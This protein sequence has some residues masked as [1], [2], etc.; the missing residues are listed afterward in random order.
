MTGTANKGVSEMSAWCQNRRRP[1]D[2]INRHSVCR[3]GDNQAG[4]PGFPDSR[5]NALAL[6]AHE[7]KQFVPPLFRLDTKQ[8]HMR[9]AT[10]TVWP[11]DRIGMWSARSVSRH[12]T[13]SLLKAGV[14]DSPSPAAALATPNRRYP[15]VASTQAFSSVRFP[16]LQLHCNKCPASMAKSTVAFETKV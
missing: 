13:P 1:Y 9:A 11:D 14:P 8:V 6:R 4:L 2:H 3:H 10:W 12:A 5:F 16:T 7:R 15:I